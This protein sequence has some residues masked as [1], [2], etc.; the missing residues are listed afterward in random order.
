MAE[1]EKDHLALTPLQLQDIIE[2]AVKAATAPNALEQKRLEEEMERE[3]RRSILSVELAKVEEEAR[4]RRQ[5]ACSHSANSKTGESV[6]RGKGHW[7]TSG[8]MHGDDT[9]S[10]IC[11]RC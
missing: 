4:W 2:A 5:N 11:Q 7:T 3:R 1:K 10:L 6:P 8:Q 9:A